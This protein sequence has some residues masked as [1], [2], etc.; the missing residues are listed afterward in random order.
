MVTRDPPKSRDL[1]TFSCPAADES[2]GRSIGRVARDAVRPAG[3]LL[4]LPSRTPVAFLR[5]SVNLRCSLFIASPQKIRSHAD[6]DTN[7][8]RRLSVPDVRARTGRA[9]RINGKR[10]YT[11]TRGG[12]AERRPERRRVSG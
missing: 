7:A 6:K 9:N 1:R 4:L 10:N 11:H 2:G 12:R 5:K 3:L 8:R